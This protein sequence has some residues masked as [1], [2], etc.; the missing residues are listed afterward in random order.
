MAAGLRDTVVYYL[1]LPL[2][3][4]SLG[5]FFYDFRESYHCSPLETVMVMKLPLSAL[6]LVVVA[7]LTPFAAKS[8]EQ[9]GCFMVDGSGFPL[10]LSNLCGGATGAAQSLSNPK[11]FRVPIKRREGN[12]PVIDVTFNSKHKFEMLFDT[13]A[14]YTAIT[15]KMARAIGVNI[16][17]AGFGRTAG[18]VVPHTVGRVA[19]VQAGSIVS[20]NL[21]VTINSYL[22]IGLLGQNFFGGYDVTIKKEVIEFHHR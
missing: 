17:G 13:G 9:Q 14:S 22:N 6:I 5:L 4:V 19:S 1:Y 15:L 18:G 21:M 16:E 12:I 3:W 20:K 8:Q 11:L 10:D 2:I 7:I